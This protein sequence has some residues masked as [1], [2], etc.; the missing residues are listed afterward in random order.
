M[1]WKAVFAA[2]PDRLVQFLNDGSETLNRAAQI[3][4]PRGQ[5]LEARLRLRAFALGLRITAPDPLELR[6]DSREARQK[7]FG[8]FNLADVLRQRVQRFFP[9]PDYAGAVP[10]ERRRA[11]FPSARAD[12]GLVRLALRLLRSARFWFS[13]AVFEQMRPLPSL[14]SSTNRRVRLDRGRAFRKLPDL[15]RNIICFLR[16]FEWFLCHPGSR[17]CSG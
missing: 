8:V 7:L 1:A 13:F 5:K 2:R 15:P 11:A 12:R 4:G 6:P 17:C 3:F 10:R 14:P 9:N 16:N